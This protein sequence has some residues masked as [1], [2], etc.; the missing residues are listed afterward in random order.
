MGDPNIDYAAALKNLSVLYV[1]DDQDILESMQRP[2]GRRIHTLHTAINGEEGLAAYHR[3]KPDVIITDIRMPVMDGLRMARQIR[4]ADPAIPIIITSAFDE[5][6]YFVE[7]IDIGVSRYV[8]KPIDIS[9]L[10]GALEHCVRE[11]VLER[12]VYQKNA[13][14]KTHLK[15]LTEYKNAVDISAIVSKAGPDGLISEVNDAFCRVLGYSR[16]EIVGKPYEVLHHPEMARATIE[17]IRKAIHEK[18]VYRGIV[19]NRK[20]NREA[21]YANLTIVP[22]LD[23]NNEVLEIIDFRQDITQLI[24]Q[25]YTDPLTGFPNRAAL[26]RDVELSDAPLLALINIDSFKEI[27]DFYGN[28]AGDFLLKKVVKV[29]HAYLITQPYAAKVYK[30]SSDEFGVLIRDVSVCPNPKEFIQT[31]HAYLESHTFRFDEYEIFLSVSSGYTLSVDDALIKADMALKAAKKS[32]KDVVC[33]ED[34]GDIKKDYEHNITWTRKIKEAIE[35]DRI[36][37]WFQ[38]IVDA[39][40]TEIVKYEC[41]MRM[42]EE[43]GS[44]IAP[45]MFLEVAYK[46]RLYHKLAQ[47]MI[48]KSCAYF[49]NRALPFSLNMT[50]SEVMNRELVGFLKEAIHA[51]GVADRLVIELLESEGIE[52]YPEVQ[53]FIH[54]IKELGCKVAIDDFGSGYSNFEH[55]LKLQVDYIK[56]DGSIIRRIDTDRNSFVIAETIADFAR[57]LGIKTVA[58]FVHSGEISRLV[59][60]IGIDY[61]QGFHL[62]KPDPKAGD[63]LPAR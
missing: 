37:P 63:E 19:K 59:E 17:E 15:I 41:L 42:V 32:R 18:Q 36:I 10:I 48:A 9:K 5:T 27:N 51:N 55:L 39:K 45:G 21:I 62:G 7:A 11:L 57:K 52:R 24:E 2:L 6:D 28:E 4:E 56:I 3:E 40:S 50:A 16:E 47:I 31:V 46:T 34:L 25:I 54:D 60:E 8:L 1:E 33:F 30:L 43:D 38:P 29:L 35:A 49:K 22:I 44:I 58:E 12:A 53:E 20:K 23:E 14:L 26:S 13:E 61:A